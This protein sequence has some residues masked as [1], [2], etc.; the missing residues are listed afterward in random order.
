MT[1]TLINRTGSDVTLYAT[2]GE[3]GAFHVKDG[4]PVEIPGD[5]ANADSADEDGYY[6]IGDGENTRV[7][8]TSA[9]ELSDSGG[10]SEERSTRRRGTNT[11]QNTE[12]N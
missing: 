7:W 9:W 5:I 2:S 1:V 10:K 3:A 8:P 6:T 11:P 12:D 4:D